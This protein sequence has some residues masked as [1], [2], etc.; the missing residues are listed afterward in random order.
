MLN[1]IRA[2]GSDIYDL[3][4]HL[5][6]EEQLAQRRREASL[7]EEN[8]AASRSLHD[9][10]DG[11]EPLDPAAEYFAA[12]QAKAAAQGEGEGDGEG[13]EEDAWVDVE[14]VETLVVAQVEDYSGMLGYNQKALQRYILHCGQQT[15]GGLRGEN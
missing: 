5:K 6:A 10:R 14:E 15:D 13:E 2:G 8:R 11:D 12:S 7:A 1:I 4:V 3:E 9:G